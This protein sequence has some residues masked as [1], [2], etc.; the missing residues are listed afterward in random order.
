MNERTS[1][2]KAIS[3]YG[4]VVYTFRGVSMMPM[5]R[6]KKDAVRLI[7]VSGNLK[8]HDIPLYVRHDGALVLHR[9]IN[10]KDG[11]YIIRGDNCSC[12]EYVKDKQ[13][14]AVVE[15]IYKGG[16]YFDCSSVL[17]KW[18]VLRQQLTLPWRR[19]LYYLRIIK[20]KIQRR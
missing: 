12:N 6:Q 2:E 11:E 16:K 13:I 20:H 8:K 3:E 15:G 14:I 1:I 5:L 18:Y 4:F 10:I 7:A 17:M 19:I 9:I